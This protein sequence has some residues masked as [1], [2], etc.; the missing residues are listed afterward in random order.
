MMVGEMDHQ[1]CEPPAAKQD[2]SHGVHIDRSTQVE[3]IHLVV[4]RTRVVLEE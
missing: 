1:G 4:M 2:K 3:A